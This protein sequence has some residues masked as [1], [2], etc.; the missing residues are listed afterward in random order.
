MTGEGEERWI[1]WGSATVVFGDKLSAFRN[2]GCYLVL[3]SHSNLWS[4]RFFLL[5]NETTHGAC[6]E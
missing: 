6:I 4:F 1:G 5:I 2:N 3:E